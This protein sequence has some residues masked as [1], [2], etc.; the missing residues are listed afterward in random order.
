[1]INGF[2]H[3]QLAIDA[4]AKKLETGAMSIAWVW[5]QD[6][7]VFLFWIKSDSIAF[8]PSVYTMFGQ[9]KVAINGCY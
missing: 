9:A 8:P 1:M 5:V 7:N 3:G 4:T 6:V 2:V